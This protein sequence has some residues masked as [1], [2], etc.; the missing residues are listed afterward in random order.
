MIFLVMMRMRSKMRWISWCNSVKIS[1]QTISKNRIIK[2]KWEEDSLK[3]SN[4]WRKQKN[5]QKLPTLEWN[6]Q[7]SQQIWFDN[8]P[9][10]QKQPLIMPKETQSSTFYLTSSCIWPP[11]LTSFWP[12]V[13]SLTAGQPH[14]RWRLMGSQLWSRPR[15]LSMCLS[16]RSNVSLM[17][18]SLECWLIKDFIT[19]TIAI[20]MM[21]MERQSRR[22][23]LSLLWRNLIVFR[24]WLQIHLEL[25]WNY[26]FWSTY[27]KDPFLWKVMNTLRSWTKESTPTLQLLLTAIFTS[28][29]LESTTYTL[30]MPAARTS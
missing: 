25:L 1:L 13:L 14:T 27:L 26:K 20:C 22:K 2:W 28:L 12:V 23:Y 30:R 24:L 8:P 10:G 19:P 9:S 3:I 6:M 18:G 29:T 11:K 5:S 15:I 4:K 7:L 16:E 17:K 21:K